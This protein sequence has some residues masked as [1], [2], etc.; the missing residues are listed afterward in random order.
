V[1]AHYGPQRLKGFATVVP[2]L[3]TGFKL[4][5]Q[6]HHH[7]RKC[8][9]SARLFSNTNPFYGAILADVHDYDHYRSQSDWTLA[10]EI[11]AYHTTANRAPSLEI[12]KILYSQIVLRAATHLYLGYL[13]EPKI[14]FL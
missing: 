11:A 10:G 1:Q 5:E 14:V 3:F 7:D 9:S 8:E 4:L 12:Q 6:S 2:Y 13:P